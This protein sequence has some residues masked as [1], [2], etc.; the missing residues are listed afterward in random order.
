MDSH[1]S[2]CNQRR[3]RDQ[4]QYP[5][6]EYDGMRMND[7]ARQRSSGE[8]S[9]VIGGRKPYEN[10]YEHQPGDSGEED[11][12][13]SVAR[14]HPD[15]GNSNSRFRCCGHHKGLIKTREPNGTDDGSIASLT[16]AL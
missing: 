15:R 10:G 5:A 9:Q 11:M 6:G 2:S 8:P 16:P 13:E 14:Q 12:V 7:G 3:L 4:Q 1:V